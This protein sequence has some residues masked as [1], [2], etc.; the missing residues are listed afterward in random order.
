M[1]LVRSALVVA[2]AMTVP[3]VPTAA[4]AD[5][6]VASDALHDVAKLDGTT[7]TLQPDRTEGDIVR[8]S[9]R[10]R[11]KRVILTMRFSEL[12]AVGLGD[13]HLF[14]IRSD[15]LN[16]LIVVDTG[17]D[18]WGGK[19]F[20][21]KPNGKKVKGCSV[22]RTID[23]AGNT[24][25]V[26]VPRSCLGKPRWVKVAMQHGTFVTQDDLYVD[27]ARATGLDAAASF[28]Y[29]PRVYR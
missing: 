26:S 17:P 6:Y 16:R 14:A 9:V 13:L 10:H 24:A 15:K 21:E 2:A 3:L 28:H 7:A 18:H 19:V 25:T 11:A 8:S 29:G 5:K 23:Y 12:S 27:D 4:H 22:R 1:K 20:V